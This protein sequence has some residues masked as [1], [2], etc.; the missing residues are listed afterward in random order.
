MRRGDVVLVD[1]IYSDRAGSKLRPA[2]VVQSD[3]LNTIIPDTV[4]VAITGKSRAAATEVML[5]PTQEP[6]AGLTRVSFAVCNNLMTLDQS[7]IH[8]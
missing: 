7:L 2:V 6:Q 3:A 4:L 1:W 5:D 8:R